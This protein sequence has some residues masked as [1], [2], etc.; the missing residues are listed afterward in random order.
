[1]VGASYVTDRREVMF[2]DP[3]LKALQASLAKALPGHIIT[4]IDASADENKL[5]LFARQR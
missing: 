1:M 3:A 4:F 2:F 5:L